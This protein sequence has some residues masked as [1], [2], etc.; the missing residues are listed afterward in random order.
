MIDG[1]LFDSSA[2]TLVSFPR[3][4]DGQYI[5]PEGVTNIQDWAFNTAIYLDGIQLP[6][7][8]MPLGEGA[9]YTCIELLSVEIPA[10]VTTIPDSCF[11]RCRSLE[12][13]SLPASVTNFEPGALRFTNALRSIEVDSSNPRYSSRNGVLFDDDHSILVCYPQLKNGDSYAAPSTTLRIEDYA[14]EDNAHLERIVLPEGLASIGFVA[15]S[16][17]AQLRSISLPSSVTTIE[18]A[19]F[20]GCDQLTSI[21]FQGNAPAEIERNAFA[22]M[23]GLTAYYFEG[24]EGFTTPAWTYYD[25]SS[26]IAAEELPLT[27]RTPLLEWMLP[28]GYRHDAEPSQIGRSG[29]SILGEYALDIGYAGSAA[30]PE[31]SVDS[32]NFELRFHA[33]RSNINYTVKRSE[34]LIKWDTEGVA[35]SPLDVNGYRTA[36]IPVESRGFMRIAFEVQP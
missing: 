33:G 16:D 35:L 11:E 1:V 30:P 20:S 26:T 14:F 32:Q 8:L 15:F 13:F 12:T 5:I 28:R 17:C 3:A 9:F 7:S 23:N 4:R 19:A 29:Y 24:A 27:S 2:T 6:S 31:H 36:S 10:G 21:Y 34:N 25:S 18:T 22:Y